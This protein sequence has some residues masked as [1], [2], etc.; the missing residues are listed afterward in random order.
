MHRR[1]LVVTFLVAPSLVSAQQPA[2]TDS[3]HAHGDS[4]TRT[5]QLQEITVTTSPTHREDPVSSFTVSPSTIQKTPAQSPWDLLRQAAGIEVHEQGQGPG[6]APTASVRGFSSD[7]STDL[8]LWVDGVPVNEPVNGHAEGYNDWNLLMPASIRELEVIKG[9]TSALFGNFAL[10][11][12]VNV[13]TLE[14]MQGTL[15][16]V[17]GG[18]Y[19]QFDGNLLTG[20][21]KEGSGGVLALRGARDGGWRPNSQY[22]L[23]QGY[24][25]LVHDLSSRVKLDAGVGLYATSWDSPGFVT[26]DQF[27]AGHPDTVANRTDGGF[28]R[29]AQER[30]SLRVLTG[31]SLL[32]RST[33]YATQSRWQLF[34]TI[35]PEPG[36]GEGSGSQ[37]EEED[38][39]YGFGLTSALTWSLPHAEVTTGI[40]ARLDHA[41]YE[42]WFT[43]NRVRDSSQTLVSARQM[44]GAGFVQASIDAGHHFRLA[45]GA[46][47]DALGT[48]STPMGGADTSASK[49]IVSPK[50]GLLYHLPRLVDLYANVARGFRQTDGVISDPALP[51]ITEW[52][53]ET[54]AKLD[55][56]RVSASAAF[57]QADVSN[58]QTFDPIANRSTSGG[59]SRRKG[60]ELELVY[61]PGEVVSVS[62]AWT[63]V[64]AK[65]QA[66]VTTDGDTLT[67]ARIF[68]T[69]RNVGTAA[70]DVTPPG[71]PLTIRLST[72]AVGPYTPFD[73]P[74]LELPAYALVH[75]GAS[76]RLGT[77]VLQLGV[78]N[79]LD[80]KYPEVRA[81]DFV[82]PGQPRS[83]FGE[84]RYV[85]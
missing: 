33:L 4:L 78:R 20:F 70:I 9:P 59:K 84:V 39:R 43:T 22:Q 19:G 28:K 53:Y 69:A 24:G 16:S 68:N 38:T 40:E 37:T 27:A 51:F 11:G 81:G 80:K 57:F 32:W 15:L 79:L 46:R 3:A 35:P 21:D 7:H 41:D 65:Y 75:A 1:L 2:R 63:F 36:S 29:R 8:A 12:V 52:A 62:A 30:V 67:G 17:T 13:R 14:R 61:R 34:L 10:S 58:E 47:Y 45:L 42:N 23:G 55:G 66:L 60:V 48:R 83:V 82:A 72:N 18:S 31:S 76:V 5:V 54:G 44:S 74:G 56:H 77:A 73:T 71:T 85:F 26:A 64:D 50:L 6:F 49:G 25:R